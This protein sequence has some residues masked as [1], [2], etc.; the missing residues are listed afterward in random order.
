MKRQSIFLIL[1]LLFGHSLPI[2]GTQ[3]RLSQSPLSETIEQPVITAIFRDSLG[4]LWVGTQ[5]GLYKFDGANVTV[6]NSNGNN[7]NWIPSS[8]IRGIAADIDGDLLVATYGGGLLKLDSLLNTFTA[9][10]H[11]DSVDNTLITSLHVAKDG[12]VW[13][14]TKDKLLLFSVN[15]E[16]FENWISSPEIKEIIGKPHAFL[17]SSPGE[18]VVGSSLGLS[19]I[20]IR[21]RTILKYDLSSLDTVGNFG[22]TALILDRAGRLVIGTDTANLA[23]LEMDEGNVVAQNFLGG[24]FKRSISDFSLHENGLVIAT[25]KGLYFSEMDLSYIEDISLQGAGLSS[26]DVVS[27][28]Q[29]EGK[30]WVGTYNGLDILSLAPFELFNK[31]NSGVHNDVLSFEQGS[32]GRIWVGTYSG[33][34]LYDERLKSH[35][36]FESE[37]H[38]SSLKDQRITA[39]EVSEEKLWVGFYRGGVQ[40]IDLLSGATYIPDVDRAS[41]IFVMDIFLDSETEDAWIA[42]NAHGLIRITNDKTYNYYNDGSLP[43]E[44]ISSIFSRP[45]FLVFVSTTSQIYQYSLENK[46]FSPLEFN[47]GLGMDNTVVFSVG[48]NQ[49]GDIFF[50][51]KD[52]GLFE[53]PHSSQQSNNLNLNQVG[54][55]TEFEYSTIYGI[56]SDAQGNLWCST[57]NGV[58]KLSESGKLINMFTKAD[59]LQ[60]DDFSFGASFTSKSGLIY[61]GGMN[62]Y[63]RFDPTQIDIDN[64]PSPMMLTGI[65]LPAK[66]SRH[67]GDLTK[68]EYLQLTHKDRFVTFQFSVLDF[69]DAEKNQF[70]YKLEG[71]DNDWIENGTRNTA[72]YTNLPPGNFVFRA[73]GANSSGIWNREGITLDLGVL[74][75]PWNSWWAKLAYAFGGLIV[76]LGLLRIYRSYAIERLSEERALE[77]FEA[78][79]RA[80]D[81]MQEQIELQDEMVLASYQHNLTTLSLVG[82]CI[83]FRSDNLPDDVRQNL[84]ESSMQRISA[85]SSL[86]ECLSYQAG[87]AVANLEKYTDGIL[88]EL[89]KRAPVRQ[90][91]IITI[92]EVTSMPLPAELASPLSIIIYELLEN[93]FQHAFEQGSPANY[94]HVKLSLEDN[95]ESSGEF[96]DLL[97]SDSGIGVPAEI[98]AL[99]ASG[100]GIAI[101]ES[102][103]AKLGGSLLFS[104]DEGTLVSIEIPYNA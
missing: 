68:L 35:R 47:F 36:R 9:Y 42:T 13:A 57:Q 96:L 11:L 1:I 94:V 67:L 19:K 29:D 82:D 3:P 76:F 92:N 49:S 15:D 95:L 102:I 44:G 54:K 74:P 46:N 27:L 23:V 39:L 78:E 26:S 33:L 37:F 66:E 103:V 89:I 53:W 6:F 71:F 85:L 75:A 21:D 93:S 5:E 98:E 62:G 16:D 59:G 25:D 18:L 24:D 84:A 52:H 88:Q 30:V 50:G 70:R 81:E 8:D 10:R 56:F 38:S 90:E 79:N 91:T 40:V 32:D 77:M 99:A 20:S 58:L 4:F 97:V 86:E 87:G 63:N 45:E 34:Y 80:D 69:T 17:E 55:G 104:G 28:Y 100:S 72:T 43:H 65:S 41:E 7:R 101:V 48:E 2:Y 14:S 64:T 73:Q 31:R 83:S 51:T 12:N 60:G 61:F 22:V